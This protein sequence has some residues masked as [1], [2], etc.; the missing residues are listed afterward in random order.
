MPEAG[1]HDKFR[2]EMEKEWARLNPP[3]VPKTIPAIPPTTP[4]IPPTTPEPRDGWLVRYGR[5]ISRIGAARTLLDL[6]NVSRYIYRLGADPQAGMELGHLYDMQDFIS[7]RLEMDQTARLLVSYEWV[8]G[9][10]R[11][12][13]VKVVDGRQGTIPEYGPV[14]DVNSPTG[15]YA[16]DVRGTVLTPETRT[17]LEKKTGGLAAVYEWLTADTLGAEVVAEASA[18]PIPEEK[19]EA[20][21]ALAERFFRID[22]PE[23]PAA[24]TPTSPPADDDDR[25]RLPREIQ[26]RWGDTGDFG[27]PTASPGDGGDYRIPGDGEPGDG[28]DPD[29]GE[30]G[31][32]SVEAAGDD[33]LAVL[34][35]RYAQ[36]TRRTYANLR[37]LLSQALVP[38]DA[39]EPGFAR[40]TDVVPFTGVDAGRLRALEG[41]ETYYDSGRVACVAAVVGASPE[42]S[43]YFE[44]LFENGHSEE[45]A[46]VAMSMFGR[47]KSFLEPLAPGDVGYFLNPMLENGG[48]WA[49]VLEANGREASLTLERS[50]PGGPTRLRR[51]AAAGTASGLFWEPRPAPLF[52]E[53]CDYGRFWGPRMARFRRLISGTQALTEDEYVEVIFRGTPTPYATLDEMHA[54]LRSRMRPVTPGVQVPPGSLVFGR[55]RTDFGVVMSDWTVFGKNETGGNVRVWP[56]RQFGPRFVWY[57][58]Q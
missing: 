3:A 57:P 11:V 21:N 25:P 56:W 53:E 22:N 17:R 46:W 38:R 33:E 24:S 9:V 4:L 29:G 7:R 13:G 27:P 34:A 36:A 39:A 52:A 47:F 45:L 2:E 26:D 32:A 6:V 19:L 48:A 49:V 12:R 40:G 41:D 5:P 20:F 1:D 30:V 14:P 37:G 15:T 10:A 8:D 35:R 58:G 23:D 28:S 55:E 44:I 50:S 16:V 43:Q 18:R 31:I 42:L 51:G 54:A